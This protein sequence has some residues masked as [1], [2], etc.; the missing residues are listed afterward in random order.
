MPTVAMRA[1]GHPRWPGKGHEHGAKR[2]EGGQAGRDER[3]P[4][5]DLPGFRAVEGVEADSRGGGSGVRRVGGE[6]GEMERTASHGRC[7]VVAVC[8][9]PALGV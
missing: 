8:C 2:V 3:H 6:R 9:R 1:L 4:E 5:E 7:M